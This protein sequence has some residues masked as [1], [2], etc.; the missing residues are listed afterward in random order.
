[1]DGETL[2]VVLMQAPNNG[3][4]DLSPDG[5]F[6]YLPKVGFEGIDNFQYAIFDGQSLSKTTTVNLNVTKSNLNQGNGGQQSLVKIYPN[7]AKDQVNLSSEINISTIRI[8]DFSG[9]LHYQQII[10]EKTYVLDITKLHAGMYYVVSE[11]G[12]RVS[13]NKL[14]VK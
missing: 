10:N 4:V 9:K 3:Y 11:V 5:S 14:L 8:F 12:G 13:A 1:M 6:I 2:V 7:P